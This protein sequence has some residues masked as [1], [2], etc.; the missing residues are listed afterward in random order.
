MSCVTIL[1]FQNKAHHIRAHLIHPLHLKTG[2]NI[3]A[4]AR[5]VQSGFVSAMNSKSMA[6]KWMRKAAVGKYTSNNDTTVNGNGNGSGSGL[7]TPLIGAGETKVEISS[8]T[9]TTSPLSIKEQLMQQAGIVHA[10]MHDEEHQPLYKFHYDGT[11]RDDAGE[12]SCCGCFCKHKPDLHQGLFWGGEMGVE[13]FYGYIRTQMVL[14]ALYL[15]TFAVIFASAVGAYFEEYSKDHH[16]EGPGGITEAEE[17]SISTWGPLL[18]F[19]LALFPLVFM[20]YELGE[21]IPLLVRITTT[22]EMVDDEAISAVLRIMKS[23]RALRAL[24]NISCFM[25]DVDKVADECR[26]K[27]LSSSTFGMLT[28]EEREKL[29]LDCEMHTYLSGHEIIKQGQI[30]NALYIISQGKVQ[31]VVDG[32]SVATLDAG[33]EFGEISMLKGHPC[34]ASIISKE[35]TV[36]FSLNKAAFEKHLR[37]KNKVRE[38]MI[39]AS[40]AEKLYKHKSSNSAASGMMTNTGRRSSLVKVAE[41]KARVS[42]LKTADIVEPEVSCVIC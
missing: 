22:E 29:M 35:R 2:H 17:S 37:G 12:W 9:I 24:H 20:L 6:G 39:E 27:A 7:N 11:E 31:V 40:G 15:G 32:I 19:F 41:V 34:N 28:E 30:N 1:L 16:H 36:C 42:D 26:A 13:I 5:S 25:A 21:L 3:R 4:K 33:K 14:V 38:A 10:S 23:R 8:T 18:V